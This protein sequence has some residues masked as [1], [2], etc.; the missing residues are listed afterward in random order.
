M[1]PKAYSV[2]FSSSVYANSAGV[3]C[4]GH[5][6]KTLLLIEASP[7]ARSCLQHLSPVREI[8]LIAIKKILKKSE[9]FN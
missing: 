6:Y 1:D 7:D 2:L 4:L 3:T 8:K 5:V 9:N